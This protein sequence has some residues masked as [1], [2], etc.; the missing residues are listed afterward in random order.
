[1]FKLA[2]AGAGLESLVVGCGLMADDYMSTVAHVQCRL[3]IC[4]ALNKMLLECN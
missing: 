1:L 3:M 2:L 4:F